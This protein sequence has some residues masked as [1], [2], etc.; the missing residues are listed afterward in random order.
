MELAQFG[1]LFDVVKNT[2][3]FSEP[4]ARYYFHQMLEALDYLHNT[5][6]ICHRDIKPQNILM[7]AKFNLKLTDFGW[8]CPLSGKNRDGK[9]TDAVGTPAYMPPEELA[10]KSYCGKQADLFA[11]A[12]SLFMMLTRCAPFAKADLKDG[13]YTKIAG[14]RPD[15]FWQ[16]FKGVC[17]ADVAADEKAHAGETKAVQEAVAAK[18]SA[19]KVRGEGKAALPPLSEDV[20]EL[21]IDMMNLDPAARPT[22]EEIRAHP[23]MHGPIPT[24][25][26]I[27]QEFMLRLTGKPD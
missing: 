26:E 24:D 12:V 21:L 3:A 5:A 22:L 25:D 27:K 13:R 4:V 14:N 17:E 16:K 11:L 10:G 1:E 6:G 23:W 7:D 19:A 8:A 18:K 20:K 2:G 15:Q 9:L